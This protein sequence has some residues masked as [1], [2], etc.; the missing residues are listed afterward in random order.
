[1]QT[2]PTERLDFFSGGTRC[3]A[4]LTLPA[5]AGPH[6]AVALVHGLGAVRD[7]M[8]PG[9]EQH[10]A[11]AG[12]ATLAFDYRYTG[13]SEGQPRQRISLRRQGQDVHAALASLRAHPA[14]DSTRL[15][16]WGTSLGAMNVVRVAAQR[17]DIAAAVVQCPIVHGPGAA[18]ALGV[19][20]A[21]RTA[22]AI[23]EDLLRAALRPVFGDDRRHIPIVG[24]PGGFALVTADGAEAG[25]NSTVPA[26]AT[27]DNRIV[28]AD[29]VTMITTSALR[30]ARRVRA[31]LLVCV[32]DRENLM[33]PRYAEAVARRAP[34]G[35]ARHYDSDHFAIY[36]APLVGQ[37]LADQTAFL[38]EHLRVGG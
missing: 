9:Y 1:M 33:H 31:P 23:A 6:P 16:L 35:V 26:G 37:V 3:A 22:P 13:S 38:Q 2:I 32:C 17:A 15:G 5:G 25:W 29:A 11:S 18:R 19:R 24:P 4:W 21:L 12:I 10:F 27:F 8:L 7:M 36:H 34:N 28:G 30:C 20:A 14:I